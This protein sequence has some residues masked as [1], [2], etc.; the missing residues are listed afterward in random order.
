MNPPPAPANAAAPVAPDR[1]N[2]FR[3]EFCAPFYER[4]ASIFDDA[5][6]VTL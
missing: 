4:L 6:N 2:L 1:L 5:S 3:Y